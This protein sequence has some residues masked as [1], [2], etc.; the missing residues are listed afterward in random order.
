MMGIF[1]I[2]VKKIV[3][4]FMDEFSVFGDS[5]DGCLKILERVLK[6][7]EEKNLVLNWE[8]CHFMVTQGIV[9]GHIVSAKGIELDKSKV[10]AISNLFTP[11][12][13]KDIKSF[14]GHAD[15]HRRLINDFSAL[16][17]PLTNLL[18][19]DVLFVWSDDCE[20]SFKN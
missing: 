18:S 17:R 10:D 4:V 7:Y 20:T 14:L 16:A 19:N 6:R 8:K 2:M 5:F 1:S 9:L 12:V 13:V 3:E 11:N 15:F